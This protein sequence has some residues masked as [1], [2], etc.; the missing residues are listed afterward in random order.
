MKRRIYTDTSAIGGCLD[1]EFR[2]PSVRL[3]E[4]FRDGLD[5]LVLSALTLTE[6]ENAP[7]AVLDVVPLLS[8]I[9]GSAWAEARKLGLA[10]LCGAASGVEVSESR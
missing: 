10:R 6:L 2:T 7:A 1:E 3:F 4:R 5:T 9:I 8:K